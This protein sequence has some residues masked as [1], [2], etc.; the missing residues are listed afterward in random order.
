MRNN[1]RTM[2]TTAALAGMGLCCGAAQAV[3]TLNVLGT[4]LTVTS[5]GNDFIVI[6]AAD[7][8]SQVNVSGQL[9]S[10]NAGQLTSLIVNGGP[11]D[12]QITLQAVGAANF[13]ALT[14]VTINGGGGA[15]QIFGSQLNDTIVDPDG[16]DSIQGETGSNVYQ[17][18][19]TGSGAATNLLNG[20]GALQVTNGATGE[21]FTVTSTSVT[22]GTQ[23]VNFSASN[24]SSIALDGGGGDDTFNL[25]A[26]T[27]ISISVDGN[28]GTNDTINFDAAG[29]NVTQTATSLTVS[30]KQPITF[31]NV[32]SVF[33]NNAPNNTNSNQN[34]N[35]NTNGT[36]GNANTNSGTNGNT[37]ADGTGNTN[38]DSGSNTNGSG[39]NNNG[40]T[41]GTN[42]NGGSS[43]NTNGGTT[44]P[45][46]DG[47]DNPINQTGCGA[48]C[49]AGM[50][51]VMPLMVAG[52]IAAKAA[53]RRRA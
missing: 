17:I 13:P 33:V 11:G 6:N 30:G 48:I 19:V 41:G 24:I 9:A 26:L 52:L 47:G 14:T 18:T 35:T 2:M 44:D 32:E 38:S 3:I 8:T 10:I 34:T 36:G 22:A 49:G 23:V 25:I 7:S 15:D 4:Q 20:P 1:L 51:P 50:M 27:S 39:A 37:N 31:S 29:A 42:T 21:T 43:G 28:T 16:G 5:S 46:S 40:S 53:R 12:Q 45:N